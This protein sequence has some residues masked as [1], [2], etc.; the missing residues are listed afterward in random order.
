LSQRPTVASATD[1]PSS[2]TCISTANWQHL[3]L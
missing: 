3:L 1:S 2:G